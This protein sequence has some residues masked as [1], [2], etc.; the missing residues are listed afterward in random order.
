MP[1]K[2]IGQLKTMS[3]TLVFYFT[4]DVTN[5]LMC[6]DIT[7]CR[8]LPT[9]RVQGTLLKTGIQVVPSPKFNF[10]YL[11]PFPTSYTDMFGTKELD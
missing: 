3:D 2:Y 4:V 9:H 1:F 8:Q 7:Y 5:Y 6:M 10:G 11:V